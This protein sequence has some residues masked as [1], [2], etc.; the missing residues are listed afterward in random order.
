MKG[1]RMKLIGK[2]SLIL[3]M[4]SIFLSACTSLSP[5]KIAHSN[6][7]RDPNP[8]VS[9]N[10]FSA[11]VEGNNALA[12]NLYQSLRSGEG[13]IV[14]SPY[15]FSLAMA[16][17]FAGARNKTESQ[18]AQALNFTLPED[19]LHPAFNKL[20]LSLIHESQVQSNGGQTL[21]LDTANAVW[22][23]QSLPFQQPFLDLLARN[24]GAGLKLGDFINQPA[25]VRTEINQWVSGQTHQKI[26]NLIPEGAIDQ[27]TRLVLVNAI[28]FKAD[29]ENQ[30]NPLNTKNAPFH[31]Q[32]GSVTQ[33][34]MMSNTF[35]DVPFTTGD[36]YKAVELDYL[37]KTAALDILVPDESKFDEFEGQLNGNKFNDILDGMKPEKLSLSVPKFSFSTDLDLGSHLASMGMPDAFDPNLADFS[38]MTGSRDLFISKVFHQAFVAVDEKGTEAAAATS[39]I[40]APTSILMPGESLTIDRPF[41]FIIRDIAN[42]QILF[43]GRILNPSN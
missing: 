4:A 22:A 19:R 30:F 5:V 13:N 28:Y 1:N 26:N 40:M 2:I 7:P 43:V 24:Y 41:I 11:L 34:K 9:E 35:I 20:D 17:T 32:D 10:D 8:S 29:W 14:F 39:V 16:M 6:L 23:E 3:V 38:G 18:M 12:F 33:A 31:L 37:G 21:Q 25:E 15:S 36:G 42:K 27:L